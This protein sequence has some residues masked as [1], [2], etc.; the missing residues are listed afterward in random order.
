MPTPKRIAL[1]LCILMPAVPSAACGSGSNNGSSSEDAGNDAIGS[2]DVVSPGEDGGDGTMG[3]GGADVGADT[4]AVADANADADADARVDGGLEAARADVGTG[5][6]AADGAPGACNSIANVAPVVISTIGSGSPPPATGGPIVSGTYYLTGYVVYPSIDA[7]SN[8]IGLGSLQETVVITGSTSNVVVASS[9]S[10]DGGVGSP[11]VLTET[12]TP[13]GTSL[14]IAVTCG[15]WTGGTFPYSS[16]TSDAGT[17][18]ISAL[19]G[20]TLLTLT[21]Q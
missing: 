12:L 13:S 3:N 21:K 5:T 4:G 8:G 17:T 9:G 1:A 6:D 18:T 2:M 16:I 14:A 20:N 15:Q 7:G 11:N 10:L 19:N